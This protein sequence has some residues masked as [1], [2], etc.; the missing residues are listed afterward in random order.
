MAAN[1]EIG[2]LQPIGDIGKVCKARGILFHTDAVQAA[3]TIPLSVEEMGIDLL[4]LSAHKIYGPKGAGAL[5]V[6]KKDPRV[7]LLPLVDGGGHERGLRSGTVAVPLVVGFGT[8]C[9]ICAADMTT[10]APRLLA[11]RERLRQG[12]ANLLDDILLNGHPTLR[13]A[14]NLNLSFAG[15]RGD[16]LLMALKNLAVSSG[17]ACTSASVEPSYVLRAIG[18]DDEQAHGSIRFGLGRFSTEEEV[19]FAV[20]EV[21]GAVKRLRALDPL[22][23][24]IRKSPSQPPAQPATP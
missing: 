14:G 21:A 23:G 3:G 13:L 1:N 2:T 4:S 16:A 22:Y 19:D 9:E 6:R 5:Y 12:I 11:L 20:E 10:E 8:A 18:R 17:S 7:R 15:V 24:M